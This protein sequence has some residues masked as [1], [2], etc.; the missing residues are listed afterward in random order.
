MGACSGGPD[1]V[2]ARRAAD[3]DRGKRQEAA[4]PSA[5]GSG[6]EQE[7]ARAADYVEGMLV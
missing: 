3:V 2:Y 1:A 5:S 7:G 4:E 6:R